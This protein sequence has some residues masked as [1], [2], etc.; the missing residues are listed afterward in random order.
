MTRPRLVLA[1][2]ALLA[3]VPPSVTGRSPVT[4]AARSIAPSVIA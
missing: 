4:S 3:P 1:P 2:L